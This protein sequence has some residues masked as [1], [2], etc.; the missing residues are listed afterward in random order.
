MAD[1]NCAAV[2]PRICCVHAH[3]DSEQARVYWLLKGRETKGSERYSHVKYKKILG[4]L[5]EIGGRT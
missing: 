2:I 3:L 4:Q 1:F 5:A